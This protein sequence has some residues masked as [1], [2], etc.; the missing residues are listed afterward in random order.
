MRSKDIHVSPADDLKKHIIKGTNCHCKPTIKVVG[1]V[2]IIIHNS[3]D[4]REII[5]QANEIIHGRT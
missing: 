5:E 3:Y 2:L 4:H 1:A